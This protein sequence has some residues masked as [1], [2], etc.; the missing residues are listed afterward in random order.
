MHPADFLA[1]PL[2]ISWSF[3][4]WRHFHL[5]HPRSQIPRRAWDVG[6]AAS[7]A[8]KP[9]YFMQLRAA[10]SPCPGEF[11]PFCLFTLALQLISRHHHTFWF[12][13]WSPLLADSHLLA[14]LS[15]GFLRK[16]F[17]LWGPNKDF[18]N[19]QTTEWISPREFWA[20]SLPLPGVSFWVY[21]IW[22]CHVLPRWGRNTRARPFGASHWAQPVPGTN[23]H[24]P[25]RHIASSFSLLTFAAPLHPGCLL[26]QSLQQP[27]TPMLSPP[28]H[29]KP[30]VCS[31][32]NIHSGYFYHS[33]FFP[34]L[35]KD[36]LFQTCFKNSM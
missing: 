2:S 16:C 3:S 5:T 24:H 15:M 29:C 26:S 25:A 28:P 7:L 8:L 27:S 30:L 12:L 14:A 35:Q 31:H 6:W 19:E 13:V 23:P 9:F 36:I 10:S 1:R 4:S 20:S 11:L 21:E 33:F 34:F 17:T 18:V 22:P 32:T